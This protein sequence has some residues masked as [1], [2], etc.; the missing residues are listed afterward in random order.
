M[1]RNMCYT[2]LSCCCTPYK[3][4]RVG[5][6]HYRAVTCVT[7]GL[8]TD[9]ISPRTQ[10]EGVPEMGR[11]MCY[12]SL[13]CCCTPYK[14]YRVGGKHYRAVTCVTPRFHLIQRIKLKGCQKWA[15]TCVTH[16]C[17]VVA[18]HTR[19]TEWSQL[20]C[21]SLLGATIAWGAPELKRYNIPF[22]AFRTTSAQ[23]GP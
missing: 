22:K 4:Y 7:P 18:L 11:N 6:K 15:V 14:V 21:C 5:G 16:H 17:L 19:C 8:V 3:V 23:I 10:I 2:S 20:C 9:S 13:S 12:T 1:G